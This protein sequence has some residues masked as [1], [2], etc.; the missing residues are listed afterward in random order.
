MQVKAAT[1]EGLELTIDNGTTA[2]GRTKT[3]SAWGDAANGQGTLSPISYQYDNNTTAITST[4]GYYPRDISKAGN[5]ADDAD[6]AANSDSWQDQAIPTA[7]MSLNN[8]DAKST[9]N[10]F[11]AYRVGIRSS[12]T[13]KSISGVTMTLSYTGPTT[14][15][16]KAA[17]FI[18]AIVVDEATS[19]VVASYG[20]AAANTTY[21]I[22]KDSGDYKVDSNSQPASDLTESGITAPAKTTATA[23]KY[24]TIIVWFEGQDAQCDDNHQDLQGQFDLGFSF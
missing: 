21:P 24:Y 12:N 11:A 2:W 20:D 15:T 19:K 8:G 17:D 1:A 18:R 13:T 4:K 23:G 16:Y 14:G 10:Y 7:P 22:K 6:V 3:F 5:L 9:D